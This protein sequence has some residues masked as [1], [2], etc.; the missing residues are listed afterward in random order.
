MSSAI[1]ALLGT[2]LFEAAQP[3]GDP[4]SRER[5]LALLARAAEG[6]PLA[7]ALDGTGLR[8]N[9][10]P[11]PPATPGARELTAAMRSHHTSRVQFPAGLEPRHWR[12]VAAIYAAPTGIHPTATH[13]RE[14]LRTISP[15]IQCQD[16]EAAA[17]RPPAGDR[18]VAGSAVTNRAGDLSS[19]STELARLQTEGRDC[20][21]RRDAAGV[22]RILLRFAELEQAEAP[23]QAAIVAKERRRVIPPATMEWLVTEAA[24][25]QS[26]SQLTDALLTLG[27]ELV[28]PVL[29]ELVRHPGPGGRDALIALL[30]RLPDLE[31]LL[32]AVLHGSAPS[33]VRGAAMVA[34]RRHLEGLVPV[35]GAHLRHQDADARAAVW[36]ALEGIGTHEAVELL[37]SRTR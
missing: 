8:L 1:V 25:P 27:G 24:H 28:E 31:A 3:D 9:E 36:H 35:L 26:P 11:V 2:A 5:T 21:E 37:N 10:V 6:E 17:G 4:V 13:V 33:L 30:G 34:E 16:G 23:G 15:L 12:E 19:F 18:T 7:L 32:A 29:D 20:A 14:A 22:A